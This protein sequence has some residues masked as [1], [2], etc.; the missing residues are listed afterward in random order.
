MAR[1]FDIL[2]SGALVVGIAA[3]LIGSC[4]APSADPK[5]ALSS[6]MGD[7]KI[8]YCV[9]SWGEARYG[10]YGYNHVV[11]VVNDCDKPVICD[12]STDV[13][14]PAIRVKLQPAQHVEVVTRRGSPSRKFKVRV[15]CFFDEDSREHGAQS[16]GMS[17][18]A[19]AS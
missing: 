12:V 11:H 14:P 15:A 6:P 2:R 5:L 17:W 16:M 9:R 8:A 18:P 13:D 19:S 7:V 10:G 1:G 4:R 3:L